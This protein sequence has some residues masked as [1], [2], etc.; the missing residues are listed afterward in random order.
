AKN[1]VWSVLLAVLVGCIAYGSLAPTSSSPTPAQRSKQLA[2]EIRCP[3]CSGLSAGESDSTLA[4][5][6]RDEIQRRVDG[7]KSNKQIRDYF[8]SRYG[9][10]ALMTPKKTGLS[11]VIWVLPAIGALIAAAGLTLVIVRWKSTPEVQLDDDLTSARQTNVE[12]I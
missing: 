7:G 1:V 6:T 4:R 8:V 9:D 12:A 5:S 3:T 11:G 2:A 10:S